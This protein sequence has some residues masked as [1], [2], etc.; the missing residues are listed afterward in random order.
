M[1]DADL[2]LALA[3]LDDHDVDSWRREHIRKRAHLALDAQPASRAVRI[4][5]SVVEPT[6]LTAFCSAHLAWAFLATA[7][8]L[9]P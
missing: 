8:V 2:D 1:T 6:L 7:S 3:E 4:Y 5:R 9:T